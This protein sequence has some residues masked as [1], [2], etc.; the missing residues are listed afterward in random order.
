MEFKYIS[1]G[2]ETLD[3]FEKKCNEMLAS[4]FIVA[5]VRIRNILKSIAGSRRL[6]SVFA[7]AAEGFNFDVEFDKAIT[8]ENGKKRV[9]LPDNPL[10][11]AAFV[12]ALFW[13][14]DNKNIDLHKLLNEYY[15]SGPAINDRYRFFCESVVAEF[16]DNVVYLYTDENIPDILS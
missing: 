1:G 13:E 4:K 9:A 2:A 14:I 15:A 6:L 10:L 12:Y 5:D 3:A 16:R 7:A 11:N 8:V